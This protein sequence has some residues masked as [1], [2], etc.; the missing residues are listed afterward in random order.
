MK[1]LKKFNESREIDAL[2]MQYELIHYKINKDGLV[3]VD[4]SVD[5]NKPNGVTDNKSNL[6]SI[7]IKFGTVSGYFNAKFMSLTTLKN[8]PKYVGS[9]FDCRDNNLTSLKYS[10]VEVHGSFYC[11]HNKLTTLKDGPLIVNGDFD[12]RFNDLTTLE[13]CPRNVCNIPRSYFACNHNPNLKSLYG[14]NILSKY[15]HHY[16]IFDSTNLPKEI[17]ENEIYINEI[18]LKQDDYQI[19]NPDGSFNDGRFKQLMIEI[20][21]EEDIDKSKNKVKPTWDID[22]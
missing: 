13:G 2:C 4:G 3:D 14:L 18:I 12:C 11:F 7:P 19:W 6:T 17:I 21:D 9:S 22:S 16:S 1:Y 20:Q 8:S 5:M 15:V 10:P